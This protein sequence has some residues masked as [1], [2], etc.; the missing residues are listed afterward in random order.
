MG[1]YFSL[2]GIRSQL[3]SFPLSASP[4][5]CLQI[6][7][8]HIK[9]AASTR[10]RTFRGVLGK[11]FPWPAPSQTPGNQLHHDDRQTKEQGEHASNQACF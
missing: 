2:G 11:V 9:I 10:V 8:H 7:C 5:C 1:P 4:A 3:K 6:Q